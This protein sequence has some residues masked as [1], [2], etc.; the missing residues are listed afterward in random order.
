[1][2]H[3][4]CDRANVRNNVVW[5]NGDAGIALY[6]SSDSSVTLNNLTGNVRE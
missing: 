4:S 2:L 1:M 5:N 3:C 6:E